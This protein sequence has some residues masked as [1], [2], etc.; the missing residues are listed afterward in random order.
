MARETL[1]RTSLTALAAGPKGRF[2]LALDVAAQGYRLRRLPF[3]AR[4]QSPGGAARRVCLRSPVVAQPG[5]HA[6]FARSPQ[7]SAPFWSGLPLH[8][9]AKPRENRQVARL[10]ASR[11]RRLPGRGMSELTHNARVPD[12]RRPPEN[13]PC[14]G[15]TQSFLLGMRTHCSMLANSASCCLTRLRCWRRWRRL[16]AV[17]RWLFYR[18]HASRGCRGDAMGCGCGLLFEGKAHFCEIFNF[19]QHRCKRSL[20]LGCLIRIRQC[21]CDLVLVLIVLFIAIGNTAV[22]KASC[23]LGGWR[24]ALRLPGRNCT[25]RTLASA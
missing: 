20:Q 2:N 7:T 19:L 15:S 3:C 23:G 8:A 17:G 12:S 9:P 6:N 13:K 11:R 24:F 1:L 22:P 10:S 18:A 21:L 5:P 16:R 4:A 14:L 25:P